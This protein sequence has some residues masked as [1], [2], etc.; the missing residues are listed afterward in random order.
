MVGVTARERPDIH[1]VLELAGFV[2]ASP[3][4]VV[5]LA[6]C[7][8]VWISK[9]PSLKIVA[10]SLSSRYPELDSSSGRIGDCSAVTAR[11]V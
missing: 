1:V 7:V 3:M 11:G 4:K 6:I 8:S 5:A 2:F 10:L 9:I